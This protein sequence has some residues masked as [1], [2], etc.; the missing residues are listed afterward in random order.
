MSKKNLLDTM[1]TVVFLSAVR[2]EQERGDL[3]TNTGE[4]L[5]RHQPQRQP[6]QQQ[7]QRASATD[8]NIVISPTTAVAAKWQRLVGFPHPVAEHAKL[9]PAVALV[10]AAAT[11]AAA[12]AAPTA[13][14]DENQP[15]LNDH[16]ASLAPFLAIQ[17]MMRKIKSNRT[18]G[19]DTD[20]R[21]QVNATHPGAFSSKDAEHLLTATVASLGEAGGYGS[22]RE[23]LTK[24][25]SFDWTRAIYGDEDDDGL[26]EDDLNEEDRHVC[27]CFLVLRAFFFSV[28]P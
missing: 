8:T 19:A 23:S 3:T 10:A 20:L 16:G 1:R 7:Q 24:A 26:E 6:Q 28:R 25:S 15:D 14:G 21:R 4:H 17:K 22:D 13:T 12:A 5:T 11:A 18:G 27:V 9:T 2:R